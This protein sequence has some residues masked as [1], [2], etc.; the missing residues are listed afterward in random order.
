MEKRMKIS[1]LMPLLCGLLWM[2]SAGAEAQNRESLRYKVFPGNDPNVEYVGRTAENNGS[3]SFDW[4]GVHLRTQVTGGYLAV[5]MTDTRGD[6]YDLFLDGKFTK[7]FKVSRDTVVT[8][9]SGATPKAHRVMLYKRTEGEQGTTTVYQFLTGKNGGLKRCTDTPARKIEFIGNSIT[10]G[11]G[12]EVT[13]GKAPFRPDTE[14]SNHSYASIVSRYFN[15]DYHLTAH[16]GY[17]VV[18]NYGD[19][20]AISDNTMRQRFF[21]TFDQN[22]SVQWDFA[23]WKPDVVVIKL[24]T[25]DLSNPD[26][27][28]TE[29][30]FVNGYLDLIASVKKVYGN[31]P[32]VCVSSCMSGEKLYRYVQEVVKRSNDPTVHFVGLLPSLLNIA[33]DFGACYHPNYE[34]QKKMSSVLIPNISTIMGWPLSNQPVE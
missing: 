29:E 30:Q 12:T 2:N 15:A 7:T 18:R 8:L 24:G 17:G 23:R 5:K 14:N 32:V 9:L 19:K 4:T 33:T 31:I 20:K 26:I 34:G 10:C 28:P 25:N 21:Q 1:V 22:P 16:S 13:D 3:V 11:F 6:F 27:C